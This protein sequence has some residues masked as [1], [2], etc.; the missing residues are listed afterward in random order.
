[1]EKNIVQMISELEMLGFIKTNGTQCRFVGMT[2]KTPVVKIKSG[3]PWGA[4]KSEKGL[5]KISRKIGLINVDY[6]ASVERRIAEQTGIPIAKVDYT[7][8]K[9]WYHHLTTVDGK[10]LPII[11]NNNPEKPGYY[12]QYFPQKSLENYF[13]NE[14][15]EVIPDETVKPWLYAEQ[16]RAEYKPVTLTVKLANIL[17]LKASGV[18]ID[19]PKLEEVESI[20]A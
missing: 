10:P 1:M 12:L 9:C 18:I 11:E 17:Q 19:M 4:G 13:I 5:Y 3:N 2:F 20:L 16:E 6:N 8:G 7:P 14:A 15:N